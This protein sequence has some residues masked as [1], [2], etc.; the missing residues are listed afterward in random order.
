MRRLPSSARLRQS[1]F[2]SRL[3]DALGGAW[4]LPHPVAVATPDDRE[5]YGPDEL[6]ETLEE[7]HLAS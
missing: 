4:P 1:Q 6:D 2:G 3:T 7:R 5:V